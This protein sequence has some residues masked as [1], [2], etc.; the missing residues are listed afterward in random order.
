MLGTERLYLNSIESG[1]STDF[2]AIVTAVEDEKISLDRTL[3]YPLGGGQNWDTGIIE[4][5][6]GTATVHEVRGRDQIVHTVGPEHNF[7][8]GDKVHGSLDW[9]RRHAHM[10]M[11]TAQ[12]LISGVVYELFNGTRTVGNQIHNDRSRIDFNP[13]SFTPEMLDETTAQVNLLIDADHLVTDSTMTREQVNS[14]MPPERTNMDLL[15]ASVNELR[16]VKIGQDLDLCPCAGTH[17]QRLG[18]I[19]HIDITGKKSKGKGTQRITYEL[20]IPKIL[21]SPNR[22]LL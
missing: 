5:P 14:Q 10:R 8:V 19:G 7:S 22:E 1:Y 20:Q 4:G 16:V 13:I 2:G 12:H 15:P 6:N 18:E 9:E 17:V 21:A 11:H 3:F